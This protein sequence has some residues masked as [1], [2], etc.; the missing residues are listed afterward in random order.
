MSPASD[1]AA[2]FISSLN[3]YELSPGRTLSAVRKDLKALLEERFP[4]LE[5]EINEKWPARGPGNPRRTTEHQSKTCDLFLGILVDEYGFI[6]KD[7]YSA[8]QVEFDAAWGQS[9]EKMLVFVQQKLGDPK[10]REKLPDDYQSLLGQITDYRTGKM[11]RW[12]E[13]EEELRQ[14]VEGAIQV[15]CADSL[16]AIRRF[17][18]YASEKSKD[19]TDWELMTFTERHQRMLETFQATTTR[20]DLP[21][22]RIG[23]MRHIGNSSGAVRYD[24]ELVVGADEVKLPALHSAC[25][26]RF[27][28]PDAARYVG[29]PFRTAVEQWAEPSGPLHIVTV[30][31]SITDTQIRKHLGNPDIHVLREQWGFFAADPERFIQVAYL[32]SCMSSTALPRQ[33]RRFLSWL[34]DYGQLEELVKRAKIRGEVLR[35]R[36]LA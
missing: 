32:V 13:S 14:Q 21:N 17:P 10:A 25:P 22:P 5:V 15:Y 8:T 36:R 27:S 23:P 24:L 7:G 19:E 11:V 26:D 20:L 9:P 3:R 12:F 30:A 29:Y 6:A 28:Y 31:R 35:A 16:K 33:L 18:A 34:D 4:F 1:R 2:V